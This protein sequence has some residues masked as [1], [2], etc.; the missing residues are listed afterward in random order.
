MRHLSAAL[1]LVL[2][3]AGTALSCPFLMQRRLSEEGRPS[4]RAASP[5]ADAVH[6]AAIA[7]RHLQV[8]AAEGEKAQ[9]CVTNSMNSAVAAL[10]CDGL[11]CSTSSNSAKCVPPLANVG[12]DDWP[13]EYRTFDGSG[14]NRGDSGGS[15]SWGMAGEPLVRMAPVDYA[16][17]DGLNH[18][19]MNR[20]NP[21]DVS[22]AI[23]NQSTSVVENAMGAT[24]LLWQWGQVRVLAYDMHHFCS[25]HDMSS[26][27]YYGAL[28]LMPA[29]PPFYP[30][31]FLMC[32]VSFT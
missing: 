12:I 11:V 26:V 23:A 24:D 6:A 2:S 14:N 8:C 13:T 19:N 9:R 4:L 22:N 30:Q 3:F 29:N 5:P 20:P 16:G 15:Q 32:I 1:A 28:L 25:I 27:R 10:C 18:M 17:A 7:R 21:R 31:L